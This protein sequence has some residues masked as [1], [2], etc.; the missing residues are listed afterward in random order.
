VAQAVYFLCAVQAVVC[1]YLLIRGYQET[2]LPLLFWSGLCFIGLMLNN[3]FLVL[4][5]VFEPQIDFAVSR[6]LTGLAGCCL[7]LYGLMW[8]KVPTT[9]RSRD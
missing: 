6:N 5:Q 8:T 4:D 2:G 3:V 7:L 1:A 9:T